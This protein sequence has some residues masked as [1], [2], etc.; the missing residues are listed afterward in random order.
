LS[1]TAHFE[2][3]SSLPGVFDED[4][5]VKFSN[6]S[7]KTCVMLKF[8]EQAFAESSSL[9]ESLLNTILG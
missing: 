2:D 8:E 9:T 5:A 4:N 3:G 1:C 6:P 7:G